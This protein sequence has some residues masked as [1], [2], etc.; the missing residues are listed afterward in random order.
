VLPLVRLERHETGDQGTFGRII[1]PTGLVLF[2]GEQPWR[3]N[4]T[5]LSCIPLGTYPVVWTWS[6]TFK[7]M[8][9]LLLGTD[10]RVGIRAHSANL[11]GDSAKGYRSQLQGCIALGERL[12]WIEG[13]KA[14]LL[15][16]P[17]VRRF[18]TTMGC[19]PFNL[20]IVNA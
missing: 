4:A 9:Y 18:E 8:M 6:R 17:A 2:T 10:P 13:Q 15:S 14:L 16:A 1:V 19:Q 3:D 7:R 11:M 20:E 5:G 12:G